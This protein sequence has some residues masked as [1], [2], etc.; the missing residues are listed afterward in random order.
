LTQDQRR[1]RIDAT[2][3][4][5]ASSAAAPGS[6]TLATKTP[7]VNCGLYAWNDAPLPGPTM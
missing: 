4:T 6:G 3:P 5:A 2:M 1:R 7:P